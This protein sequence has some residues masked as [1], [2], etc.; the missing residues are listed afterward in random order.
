[1]HIEVV[2]SIRHGRL[3]SLSAGLSKPKPNVNRNEDGGRERER[4]KERNK[5]RDEPLL[6]RERFGERT[7]ITLFRTERGV[8]KVDPVV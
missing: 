4:E 1:M 2:R 3:L 6:Y 5:S 7:F 8:R